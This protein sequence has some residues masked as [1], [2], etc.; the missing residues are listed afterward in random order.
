MFDLAWTEIA[1]VVVVALIAIGPKDMPVA[2]RAVTN[3][4]KKAR[5][6]ASE[7]QTHVDEMVKDANLDEVRNQINEIRNFDVKGAVERA[8]D[9]DGSL[10]STFASN[11]LDPE[12]WSSSDEPA[13]PAVEQA[14][15]EP[16][17]LDPELLAIPAFIPPQ[18]ARPPSPP[19]FVPPAT[20]LHPAPRA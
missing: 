2:L 16:E 5:R 1:V 14:E 8:V 3:A 18:I 17:P 9:P 20:V 13:P 6:M 19:A 12:G 10:S 4:S 11:P 15:L 7:F